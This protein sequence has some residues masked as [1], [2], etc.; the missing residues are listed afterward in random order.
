M[1]GTA[2]NFSYPEELVW[3]NSRLTWYTLAKRQVYDEAG[4]DIGSCI[5]RHVH[6]NRSQLHREFIEYSEGPNLSPILATPA[7]AYLGHMLWHNAIQPILG[8]KPSI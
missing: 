4:N 1:K 5:S 7:E 6:E 3:E 2:A 8:L